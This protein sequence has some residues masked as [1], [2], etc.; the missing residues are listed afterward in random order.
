[1]NKQYEN[2]VK[3][4]KHKKIA[5]LLGG[6]SSERAI[7]LKTGNAILGALK[8]CG[9][10]AQGL[11]VGRDFS[12]KLSKKTMDIA[13]IALHGAG[14]EDGAIQSLLELAGIPY[15]GSGVLASALAMDKHYSKQMFRAAGVPTPASLC[16]SLDEI[17]EKQ[18]RNLKNI[19]YPVV[20]KPVRQGSAIG[21]HCVHNKQKLCDALDDVK[22]YENRALVE[23]YIKGT[24]LTVG[25]V[26]EHVLPVIEIVPANEFYDFES[27]YTQGKSK[28]IIPARVSKKMQRIA[29]DV[30]QRAHNA[31]GCRAVSR[32]DLIA[33]E[34]SVW[35]LEVNTIPGMT[36]TSLLP[37][38][39]RA[40]GISFDELV[41]LILDASIY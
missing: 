23:Q 5:V 19:K 29:Q 14:G 10:H 9:L 39:A 18:V 6:W 15:T 16:V 20:V 34:Q 11:D 36:E 22:Q 35:V 2:I 26:G 7:S 4:F 21:V 28:H 3:K 17:T 1:M 38:A 30:A 13:Y 31:L 24:E 25:I 27:K 37:D 33:D 12:S 41:L 32:V 8:R 40:A